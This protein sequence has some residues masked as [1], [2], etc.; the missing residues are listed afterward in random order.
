MTNANFRTSINHMPVKSD[1]YYTKEGKRWSKSLGR[2]ITEEEWV[3]YSNATGY[4]LP[5]QGV[6]VGIDGQLYDDTTLG[7]GG[8]AKAPIIFAPTKPN[9]TGYFW[10]KTANTLEEEV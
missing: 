1:I 6:S 3:A 2:E 10:V 7:G 4:G 9:D 8:S 5:R